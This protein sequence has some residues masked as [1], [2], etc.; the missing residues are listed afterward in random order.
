[1][2]CCVLVFAIRVSGRALSSSQTLSNFTLLLYLMGLF[3]YN[4]LGCWTSHHLLW[5]RRRLFL[6]LLATAT[7]IIVIVIE[8]AW[9]SRWIDYSSKVFIRLRATIMI[10]R[11]FCRCDHY[12]CHVWISSIIPVYVFWTGNCRTDLACA[13]LMLCF[14]LSL[15]LSG[16]NL[17]SSHL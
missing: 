10:W 14:L 4:R 2:F 3:L 9:S 6:R 16:W 11:L 15:L 1:M 7:C 17:C 13:L 8:F 12:R 5:R